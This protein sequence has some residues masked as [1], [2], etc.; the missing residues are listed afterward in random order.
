MDENLQ[1]DP[2][3]AG[4][5]HLPDFVDAQL[6]REDDPLEIEGWEWAGASAFRQARTGGRDA[7]LGVP[8]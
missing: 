3:G 7:V 4:F 6:P 1:V 8:N 5:G 2:I